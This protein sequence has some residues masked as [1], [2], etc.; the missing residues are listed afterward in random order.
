MTAAPS[1]EKSLVDAMANLDIGEPKNRYGSIAALAS[2][3]A[4]WSA[5]E[6]PLP[7]RTDPRF[8]FFD[9]ETTGVGATSRI[10]QFGATTVDPMTLVE[11][12]RVSLF[13]RAH[14]ITPDITRITHI[15]PDRVSAEPEFAGR[16]EQIFS[17]LDGAVWAGY[18]IIKFDIPRLKYEFGLLGHRMPR[19]AGILDVYA[20]A[21]AWG[22]VVH[23]GNLK[24]DTLSQYYGYGVEL[25]DASD[26]ALKTFQVLR[27]MVTARAIRK[28]IDSRSCEMNAG[29]DDDSLPPATSVAA[30]ASATSPAIAVAPARVPLRDAALASRRAFHRGALLDLARSSER[31]VKD[32]PTTW[33]KVRS[34]CESAKFPKIARMR[35][36]APTPSRVYSAS[37]ST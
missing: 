19:C 33:P 14:G 1:A 11:I 7:G 22:T 16:A 30:A 13:V 20:V 29:N 34:F 31:Q 36:W 15:A 23:T 37:R 25:H 6:F 27:S 24:L 18:N 2:P 10:I 12:S 21:A 28:M 5:A 3:G 35:S 17:V 8:V 9:L 32:D 4:T 26:D